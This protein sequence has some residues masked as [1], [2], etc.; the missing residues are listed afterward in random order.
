MVAL[1]QHPFS[2]AG[3]SAIRAVSAP[4]THRWSRNGAIAKPEGERYASGRPTPEP[5]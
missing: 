1:Q 4:I 5:R 2:L 3:E